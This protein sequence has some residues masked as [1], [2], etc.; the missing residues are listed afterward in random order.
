MFE[1]CGREPQGVFFCSFISSPLN[2]VLQLALVLLV[3]LGVK[4][5]EILCLG[6]PLTL[7]RGGGGWMWLGIVFGVDG[8]RMET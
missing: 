7:T 4:D 8:S 5:S 3:K 6:S 2:K 1:F